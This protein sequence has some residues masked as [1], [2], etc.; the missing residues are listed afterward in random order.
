MLMIRGVPML[1]DFLYSLGCLIGAGI[2]GLIGA[3]FADIIGC[4]LGVGVGII[5]AILIMNKIEKRE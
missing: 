4:V 2:G 3:I 1:N 5:L